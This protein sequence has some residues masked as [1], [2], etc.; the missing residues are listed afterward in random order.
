MHHPLQSF[1]FL[2]FSGHSLLSSP[3]PIHPSTRLSSLSAV[4]VVFH[5]LFIILCNIIII[6]ILSCFKSRDYKPKYFRFLLYTLHTPFFFFIFFFFLSLSVY[7][8]NKQ[9][10]TIHCENSSQ[11][12]AMVHTLTMPS[13]WSGLCGCTTRNKIFWFTH[14]KQANTPFRVFTP[15]LWPFHF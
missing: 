1:L 15:P 4:L 10:L 5:F 6:V 14:S 7:I 2:L 8:I 9:P 11:R 12:G 3:P 13:D